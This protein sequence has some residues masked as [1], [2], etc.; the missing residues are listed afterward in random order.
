MDSPAA[1]RLF[2]L[3]KV[4]VTERKRNIT[5]PSWLGSGSLAGVCRQASLVE[6][7]G[8]VDELV[9]LS[10]L[11]HSTPKTQ[12]GGK[13]WCYLASGSSDCTTAVRRVR[14]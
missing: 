2:F 12:S 9:L 4:E 10:G 3:V 7:Q 5:V 13:T 11:D 8:V 1:E 14:I 6:T